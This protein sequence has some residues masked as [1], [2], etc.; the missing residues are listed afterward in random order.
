MTPT[1]C[2]API[3][4]KLRGLEGA[5]VKVMLKGL[6][7]A[8]IEFAHPIRTPSC[9]P[10]NPRATRWHMRWLASCLGWIYGL[11][12]I[13]HEG[14]RIYCTP[15][16]KQNPVQSFEFSLCELPGLDCVAFFLCAGAQCG[17]Y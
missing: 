16:H 4:L 17:C 2:V 11:G 12:T 7:G 10:S 14:W 5:K 6:E 15:E 3:S 13:G 8:D 1:L 9:T